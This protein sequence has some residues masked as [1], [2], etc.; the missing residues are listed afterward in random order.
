M[1]NFD[2]KKYSLENLENWLHDALSCDDSTVDDIYD[3]IYKVV[4]ENYSYHKQNAD[5]CYELM[6]RLKGHRP[7]SFDDITIQDKKYTA[8]YTEEE[9]NA[10]CDQAELDQLVEQVKQDGGYEWTPTPPREY[11]DSMYPDIPDDLNVPIVSEKVSRW[12]LP[13]EQDLGS[14][15][16]YITLPDDLLEQV[17]WGEGEQLEWIDRGDGSFELRKVSNSLEPD[18][19]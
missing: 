13:V 3:C 1:S 14:D 15:D 4:S 16:C 5:R 18:E 8:Q 11:L 2:Y 9:L 17:N 6:E 19:C 10:M 7:I 12:V